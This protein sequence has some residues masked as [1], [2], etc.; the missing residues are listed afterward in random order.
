MTVNK[1]NLNRV[2]L[3][4]LGAVESEYWHFITSRNI[5]FY[6]HWRDLSWDF[7][8]SSSVAGTAGLLYLA[9]WHRVKKSTLSFWGVQAGITCWVWYGL[10]PN[11]NFERV[12]SFG[13]GTWPELLQSCAIA[14]VSTRAVG[15]EKGRR[16]Q[17][18]G[19][20]IACCPG[21][22]VETGVM[23]SVSK[24]SA[25]GCALRWFL[26]F[27]RKLLLAVAES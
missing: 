20:S 22:I 9:E 24:A 7:S 21:P 23:A 14:C 3:L 27:R 19:R 10:F 17:P 12:S 5:F 6:F 4:L 15:K 16:W 26:P 2:F 13:S 8:F 11:G 18:L 1:K 25:P